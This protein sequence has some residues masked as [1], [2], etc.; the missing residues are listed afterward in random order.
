MAGGLLCWIVLIWNIL[1]GFL[2]ADCFSSW[3]CRPLNCYGR[4]WGGQRDKAGGFCIVLEF[5][6]K[7][8][9]EQSVLGA[10]FV[11][12]CQISDTEHLT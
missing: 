11:A 10:Y 5:E 8:I 9:L 2:L 3:A 7:N 1:L 4:T 6:E 12:F